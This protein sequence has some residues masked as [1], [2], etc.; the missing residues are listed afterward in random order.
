MSECVLNRNIDNAEEKLL[1]CLNAF[2]HSEKTDTE[3]ENIEEWQRFYKSA[4]IHTVFPMVYETIYGSESMTLLPE[5]VKV[6]FKNNVRVSV[7]RQILKT[8]AFLQLYKKLLDENLKVL[9]VKGIICRNM[10]PNPDARSSG[11]EDMYVEEA[12]FKRV[13]DIFLSNGLKMQEGDDLDSS[14]VVTYFDTRTGL[15]IELHRSL[16]SKENEAYGKLNDAFVNVFKNAVQVKINGVDIWT[17]SEEE[18]LLYLIFH[19]FKHFLHSGF[20]IRQVC[21]IV[22]FAQKYGDKID[23]YRLFDTL[24]TFGADVFSANLFDIGEKYLGI[25]VSDAHIPSDIWDS[26]SQY[27][28]SDELLRDILDSGVYGNSSMDRKHSSLITLNAV[29]SRGDS[30]FL[31]AVFP[32]AVDLKGRYTYLQKSP[33]LLPVAWTS[34]IFSYMKGKNGG[35]GVGAKESIEIGNHR[36]EIMKKYRVIR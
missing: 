22:L 27:I 26:Y 32:K 33:W 31:R 19:G 18:H 16:F 35:S 14:Q 21:D 29:T 7:T 25:S 2:I 34:R 6:L 4:S 5:Q 36:V 20:G 3:F 24:K 15:H 30:G 11:D 12:S 23:M 8:E 9:V 13:H 10:Y 28:D 17:M 1:S